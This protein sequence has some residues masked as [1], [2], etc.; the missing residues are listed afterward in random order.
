MRKIL[1]SASQGGR[2][3]FSL[4]AQLDI[5]LVNIGEQ[6]AMRFAKAQVT[7]LSRQ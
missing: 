7:L 3:Q 6:S 2:E 4:S 5:I 1:H